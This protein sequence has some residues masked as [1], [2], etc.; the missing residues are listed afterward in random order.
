MNLYARAA[1]GTGADVRLTT[2]ANAQTPNSVTPDGTFVIGHEVRPQAGRDLVRVALDGGSAG[3]GTGTSTAEGLVETPFEEGNG[4]VSPDGRFLAYQSDESGRNEIYVRPYPQ[5]ANGK[6]Q[7]STGG[8][9]MPAW[10]RGGRELVF[11]DGANRLIAV[12]VDA[13][14]SAFGW[15]TP[16]ML[17]TTAYATP[18]FPRAYDVSPDGQRFLMIKEGAAGTETAPP[19]SIVVVQNWLEELKRLVPAK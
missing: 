15:R 6:W 14:G 3:R 7:V 13:T 5:A 4:E 9:M 1:D 16:A 12:S 11:L 10:T 19:A 18:S 17:F 2:S 8:G